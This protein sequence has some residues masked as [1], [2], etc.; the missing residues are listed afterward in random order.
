LNTLSQSADLYNKAL[1]MMFVSEQDKYSSKRSTMMASHNAGME[2]YSLGQYS[3]AINYFI[4]A[5]KTM[6]ANASIAMNLLQAISQRGRLN[7][8]LIYL[9]HKCMNVIDE[10]ELPKDQR[11]RYQFIKDQ[12][13]QML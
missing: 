10:A 7:E 13:Q 1:N 8:D 5:Q 6:P 4:E 12:I 2:A 11:K 9:A 3:E